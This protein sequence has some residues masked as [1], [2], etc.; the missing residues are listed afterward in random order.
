MLLP[1]GGDGHH[2][3]DGHL[4]VPEALDL[5]DG[6][7]AGRGCTPTASRWPR[8]RTSC[9]QR[10]SARPTEPEVPGGPA[11]APYPP[12]G[13]A[14]PGQEDIKLGISDTGLWEQPSP[15]RIPGWQ[16][17]SGSPTRRARPWPAAS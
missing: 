17:S 1:I 12:P 7:S 9:T 13:C 3:D 2:D 10:S 16:V 5:I 14:G 11:P 8:R 6:A 4:T 15:D